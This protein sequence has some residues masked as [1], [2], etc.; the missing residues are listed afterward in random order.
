MLKNQRHIQILDILKNEGFAG[1][2]DLSER[3]YSS[4]PTIRRDLDFLEKQGYIRRS[5]GGAIL[6]DDR[7]NTPISFRRGTRFHEKT[8]ICKLAATLVEAGNVIFIDSS[9]TAWPLADFLHAEDDVMVVT[10]SY[11]LCLSLIE[12]NVNTFST[13]GRLYKESMAFVG[14]RAAETVAGFNADIMFF[15]ASSL[16]DEGMV[17][18][19]FEEETAIRKAMRAHSHK[20]VFLCDSE[21]FGSRAAFRD[22][23]LSD[24]DYVVTDATLRDSVIQKCRLKLIATDNGVMMYKK[25]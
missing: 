10:N 23:S 17:S 11:P 14:E 4:Q 5:H 21:K 9:T 2:R 3:L 7:L 12:K 16:D 13:G 18:D 1:V 24:V 19:C 22:I 8:L 20:N 25:I 6:A 15:S